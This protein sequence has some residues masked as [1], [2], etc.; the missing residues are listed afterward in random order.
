MEKQLEGIQPYIHS[1][2]KYL[3]S[4]NYLP[5][6]K[7]GAGSLMVTGDPKIP[8]PVALAGQGNSKHTIPF[9]LSKVIISRNAKNKVVC[10]IIRENYF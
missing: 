5:N 3:L 10:E 2:T 9:I 8:A 6:T 1:S 7:P 4:A